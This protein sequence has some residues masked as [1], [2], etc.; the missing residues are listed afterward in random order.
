ME[1]EFGGTLNTNAGKESLR[2]S[3]FLQ[4]PPNLPEFVTGTRPP[5]N[6]GH[7]LLRPC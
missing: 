4:A 7:S 2:D 1:D 3:H 6:F 5:R